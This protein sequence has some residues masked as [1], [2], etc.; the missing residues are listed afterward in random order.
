MVNISMPC[1][2]DV[3]K[4]IPTDRQER[5]KLTKRLRPTLDRYGSSEGF[6]GDNEEVE[7]IIR[8]D[9]ETLQRLGVSYSQIGERL[10][11][12]MNLDRTGMVGNYKFAGEITC[13][14][15]ECPWKDG[16]TCKQYVMWLVPSDGK[17]SLTPLEVFNTPGTIEV[18]GLMPHLIKDHYFFEGHK[19]R[20]RLDPTQISRI[21]FGDITLF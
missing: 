17:N 5:E 16:K 15:Q 12:L 2:E 14:E 9:Y 1:L 20:Y 6:M 4:V 13:G 7:E 19:S 10:A 8:R 3:L 18:S 21:I 11:V